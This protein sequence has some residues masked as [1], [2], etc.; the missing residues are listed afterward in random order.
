MEFALCPASL[1]IHQPLDSNEKNR[2]RTKKDISHLF[3][4]LDWYFQNYSKIHFLP[5]FTCIIFVFHI[6]APEQWRVKQVALNVKFELKSFIHFYSSCQPP[7]PFFENASPCSH[8]ND[9]NLQ[10]STEYSYHL[11]LHMNNEYRRQKLSTSIHR[12]QENLLWM[13]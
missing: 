2:W 10:C 6:S 9:C 12:T 1:K 13:K 7:A 3:S 8:R 5:Y 11:D 4:S